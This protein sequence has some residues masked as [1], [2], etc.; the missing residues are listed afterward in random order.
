MDEMRRKARESYRFRCGYCGVSEEDTGAELEID[1]HRPRSRGGGDE[2]ENL[3]YCCPKCNQYKGNYW[4]ETD[5]PHIRLLHPQRDD[6]RAHLREEDNGELVGKTKEGKFLIQRLHLNRPEL[7]A[8]H[9]KKRA[10]RQ[11]Q[12]ELNAAR[13]RERALLRRIEEL[14]AALQAVTA[15]IQEEVE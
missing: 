11:L 5:L 7:I 14:D 4:H 10:E 13:E 3:V 12:R 8:Y 6:L 15:Q 2:P 1:H 9:Q